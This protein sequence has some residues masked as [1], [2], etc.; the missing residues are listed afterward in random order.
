MKIFRILNIIRIIVLR[1]ELIQIKETKMSSEKK[2]KQ[3][4]KMATKTVTIETNLSKSN[5]AYIMN[6]SNHNVRTNIM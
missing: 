4:Q 3:I 1:N 6:L 2:I 5:A